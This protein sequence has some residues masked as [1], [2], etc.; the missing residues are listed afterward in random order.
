MENLYLCHGRTSHEDG[1]FKQNL[2]FTGGGTYHGDWDYL[3]VAPTHDEAKEKFLNY[4][5]SEHGLKPH[6]FDSS[7]NIKE[8]RAGSDIPLEMRIK[9]LEEV[10]FKPLKEQPKVAVGTQAN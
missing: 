3:V 2:G 6:R 10:G 4:M 8:L 1:S 5:E 7:I 9:I